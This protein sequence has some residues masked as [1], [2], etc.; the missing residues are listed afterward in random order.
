MQVG[1]L[2]SAQDAVFDDVMK[3]FAIQEWKMRSSILGRDGDSAWA[4]TPVLPEPPEDETDTK[5]PKTKSMVKGILPSVTFKAGG[6]LVANQA[7]KFAAHGIKTGDY[8]QL[9]RSHNGVPKDAVGKV[10]KFDVKGMAFVDFHQ[11]E[12]DSLNEDKNDVNVTAGVVEK[13]KQPKKRK[14]EKAP[15]VVLP[16]G[17]C[18]KLTDCDHEARCNL[19]GGAL[20]KLLVGCTTGTNLIRCVREDP[21]RAGEHSLVAASNI[22]KGTLCLIPYNHKLLSD[23][24]DTPCAKVELEIKVDEKITDT[25]VFWCPATTEVIGNTNQE[26]PLPNVLN[27]YWWT[28]TSKGDGLTV[29]LVHVAEE[30]ELPM[31]MTVGKNSCISK[32]SARLPLKIKFMALTN[33]DDIAKGTRLTINGS[34]EGWV[35]R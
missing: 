18:Y 22:K 21:T 9:K 27:P 24:P 13:C 8:V 3:A 17:I 4:P 1:K 29:D 20:Y 26:P 5:L 35:F 19:V 15:E 11:D 23:K 30:V 31:S 14:L 33:D 2:M 32:A 34:A 28:P 6:G 25:H 7:S 12:N 16:D 10:T